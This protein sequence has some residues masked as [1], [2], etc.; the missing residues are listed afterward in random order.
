MTTY[1]ATPDEWAQQ[2]DWANRRVFSYSSCIIELRGRI[3]ALEAAQHAHVEAKAAE[4]GARCA[5]EQIRSKPGSWQSL[6][7]ATETTYGDAHDAAKQILRAPMVVQGTFEHG[8]ETYRFKTK[9]ERET[10][11]DEPREAS[12]V[13]RVTWLIAKRFSE[14]SPGTDCTPFGR[15]AIREVAAALIDWW[16][17]DEVARTGWEAAKWLESEANR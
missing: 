1:Q 14:S 4:A 12:L 9:P 11:M 6:K 17:S 5:V 7:V 10:A 8:G 16:D 13:E 3:E 15:A 2:E